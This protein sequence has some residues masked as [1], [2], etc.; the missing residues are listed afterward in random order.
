[1]SRNRRRILVALTVLT[2]GFAAVVLS[3]VVW[4]VVLGIAAAYVLLP[5]H[6]WLMGR[7]VPAYWSAIVSSL[8]IVVL[9][10]VLFTPIGVVLFLRRQETIEFIQDTPDQQEFTIGDSLVTIDI[11]TVQEQFVP[12]LSDL[13]PALLAQLSVLASKFVVFAFVVFALLYYHEQL[14]PL[15][16]NAIPS[17]YHGVVDAVH[18][19]VRD[20]LFG[21]YVLAVVGLTVT[22]IS[23]IA[24]FSLLGYSLPLVFSLAAALLWILPFVSPAP[25]VAGLGLYHLF[26]GEPVSAL[27][28]GLFGILFLVAIPRVFVAEGRY[29]LDNPRPLSSSVYF[30]GF[31]GGFLT[32]GFV[33]IVVGPLAL[34]ILGELLELLSRDT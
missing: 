14:R 21:H 19:R 24:V 22:Y 15:A 30:I 32:V 18:W 27:L 33:G 16:Y 34:A 5:F 28:I 4:T 17:P 8:F 29:R 3:Q 26:V 1:M 10:L 20:V 11:D 7:G 23:G 9:V 25:L 6:K 2:V 12:G 13:A 31:V